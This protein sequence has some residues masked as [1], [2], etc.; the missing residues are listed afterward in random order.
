MKLSE[1]KIIGVTV[2]LG[3]SVQAVA[4]SLSDNAILQL[5]RGAATEDT[6]LVQQVAQSLGAEG[7]T[8]LNYAARVEDRSALGDGSEQAIAIFGFKKSFKENNLECKK[9]FTLKVKVVC[10]AI[11]AEVGC[12]VK[13]IGLIPS[14]TKCYTKPGTTSSGG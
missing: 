13:S 8:E 9:D 12:T 11:G 3:V 6:R 10:G 5:L 4:A 1:L 2:L 14:E 7:Y